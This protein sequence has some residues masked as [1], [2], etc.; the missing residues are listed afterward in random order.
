LDSKEYFKAIAG[1][2]KICFFCSNG[3][4]CR[5]H[6]IFTHNYQQFFWICRACLEVRGTGN[7]VEQL[8]KIPLEKKNTNFFKN[9]KS[10]VENV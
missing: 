2:K 4:H 1:G 5:K 8:E 7:V 9:E 6:K 3:T 10:E